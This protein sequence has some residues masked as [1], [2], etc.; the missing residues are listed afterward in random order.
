MII[1]NNDKVLWLRFFKSSSYFDK[2][3]LVFYLENE[4]IVI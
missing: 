3:K 2:N 4:I 1:Y